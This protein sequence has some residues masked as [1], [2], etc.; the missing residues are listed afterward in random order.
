MNYYFLNK[1]YGV[2]FLILHKRK[3][4]KAI[5]HTN[6]K[7]GKSNSFSS[8]HPFVFKSSV[9]NEQRLLLNQRPKGNFERP[10]VEKSLSLLQEVLKWLFY[11]G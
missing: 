10:W 3:E 5:I 4:I 9:Y 11:L 2:F 7:G 8:D 1:T 6:D